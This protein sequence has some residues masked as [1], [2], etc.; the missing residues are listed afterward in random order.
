M[1]VERP[2]DGVGA[3]VGAE[4]Q[5]FFLPG[6]WINPDCVALCTVIGGWD[7]FCVRG[8]GEVAVV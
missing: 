5:H 6:D 3:G 7:G 4:K 8:N 1:R 2:L